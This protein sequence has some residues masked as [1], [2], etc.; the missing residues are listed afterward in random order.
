MQLH[1]FDAYINVAGGM[2]VDE[3]AADLGIIC[4]I[5]SSFKNKCVDPGT[6]FFGEVG[7]TG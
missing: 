4:A 6:V 1:S 5:A 7:L 3:P 2:K